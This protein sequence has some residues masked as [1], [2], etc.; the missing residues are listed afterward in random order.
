MLLELHTL[1]VVDDFCTVHL[2]AVISPVHSLLVSLHF[3]LLF[4][5]NLPVSKLRASL[6]S[7]K[8][9]NIFCDPLCTVLFS[10]RYVMIFLESNCLATAMLSLI[11]TWLL[12]FRLLSSPV[13]ILSCR[14]EHISCRIFKL[15]RFITF[16]VYSCVPVMTVY[17]E[18]FT[19]AAF[20]IVIIKNIGL[21]IT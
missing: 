19:F 1:R 15:P 4:L 5:N 6:V 14:A 7:E 16:V 12:V 13:N 17:N 3:V 10:L 20:C 11:V 21:I 2:S 8:S 18:N 9:E